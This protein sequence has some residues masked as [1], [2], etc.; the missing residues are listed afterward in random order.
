MA[1]L[2]IAEIPYPSGTMR[3]R[4]S[5]YLSADGSSWIRHGQ[6]VSYHENGSVASEGLYEHGK[7]HGVWRDYHPNGQLAAEG[8]Y[9][10][11]TESGVWLYW[12][13]SGVPESPAKA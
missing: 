13:A 7:E 6:F 11:G 5:R 2:N 9:A 4:Y 3:F 1:D 10:N 8:E 12:S